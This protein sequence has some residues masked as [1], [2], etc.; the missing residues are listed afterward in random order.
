MN[1]DYMK[2]ITIFRIVEPHIC[3]FCISCNIEFIGHASTLP[4]KIY[5]VYFCH[6]N[7]SSFIRKKKTS[8]ATHGHFASYD[9]RGPMSRN[10]PRAHSPP[11]PVWRQGGTLIPPPPPPHLSLLLPPPPEGAASQSLAVVGGGG[12][13]WSPRVLGMARVVSFMAW[14]WCDRRAPW[15]GRSPACGGASRGDLERWLRGGRRGGWEARRRKRRS[16]RR[17]EAAAWP[18]LRG[19][20]AVSP[21]LDSRA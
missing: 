20:L 12:D 6:I 11:A 3:L 4:T 19:S 13:S 21:R 5:F 16:W 10:Q 18:A 2:I 8:V 1:N 17:P 7:F 15:R 9:I 14:A